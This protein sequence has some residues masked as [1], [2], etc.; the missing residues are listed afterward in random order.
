MR[1]LIRLIIYG[2]EREINRMVF[3]EKGRYK[4]AH[5]LKLIQDTLFWMS[6]GLMQ[7]GADGKLCLYKPQG[8]KPTPQVKR[9]MQERVEKCAPLIRR[10]LIEVLNRQVHDK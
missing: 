5:I 4:D 8:P 10:G 6:T 1:A 7:F 3:D 2:L 9:L